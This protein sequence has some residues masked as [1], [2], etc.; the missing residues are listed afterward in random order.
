[1]QLSTHFWQ[2]LDLNKNVHVTFFFLIQTFLKWLFAKPFKISE[3]LVIEN[4]FIIMKNP[5]FWIQW[6]AG[7]QCGPL[8][9]YQIYNLTSLNVCG[10]FLK[11]QR[12][13][14]AFPSL[15]AVTVQ[16]LRISYKLA[17]SRV[18]DIEDTLSINTW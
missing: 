15:M 7:T 9:I 18:G 14:L 10:S 4:T 6:I 17:N 3:K 1:M 16:L 13:Y 11:H 5:P 8:R 12:Q 2:W